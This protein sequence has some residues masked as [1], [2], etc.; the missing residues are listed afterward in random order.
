M[1]FAVKPNAESSVNEWVDWLLQLH[2][3]EI[4]LGLDRIRKVATQ[5]QLLRPAPQVITV[6]GTNGK[7]STVA[8]LVSVLRAAGFQV[9][10]Y[11][12]PHIQRFNERIAINGSPVPDALISGA[13]AAIEAQRELTKL[14]YFEFSTLA[15]LQV[16]KDA[17]LDIVVLEV[18]L[19]GR[20]DAVNVVDA[21]AV[22]ITAIDIDHVD[23]LG[24]N[25]A[26]IALEKAGVTRSGHLAVCSDPHPPATLSAFCVEREV[27]LLRLNKDFSFVSKET[28]D[29]WTFMDANGVSLNLP[30]PSLKGDFQLQNASGVVAL[31]FALQQGGALAISV[32]RLE[33]ALE[34]GLLQAKHPGRLQSLCFKLA[35]RFHHWLVDVAHNPQSAKVLAEYLEQQSLS[36]LHMLFSVLED[37]DSLP[38]VQV[39]A[40][41]VAHWTITDLAIPRGASLTKL[42]FVLQQAG[43]AAQQVQDAPNMDA[44]VAGLLRNSG[45]AQSVAV[46]THLVCGSFF[47]VAQFYQALAR[48]DAEM[49]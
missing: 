35:G 34:L 32:E 47:T 46:P 37:K 3:Q 21:D 7:G 26:Q 22:I 14:T 6:A 25:R 49:L 30:A 10:S 48:L 19:G 31:L 41:Y 45:A 1:N 9:G 42:Q 33:Q 44:A 28:K 4:D 12:S 20:L 40:P 13:F 24:D 36:D 5:M 18:G 39:L 17:Q 43:I 2:A 16:F 23:W 38:M 29:R 15:A 27:P 11:T 8:M